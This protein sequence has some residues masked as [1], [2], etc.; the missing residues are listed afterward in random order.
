MATTGFS[1]TLKVPVAVGVAKLE[2]A[3]TIGYDWRTGDATVTVGGE[4]CVGGNLICVKDAKIKITA[5]PELRP[6]GMN[7]PEEEHNP[8]NDPPL[9][10]PDPDA[11]PIEIVF[12]PGAFDTGTPPEE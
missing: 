7:P 11:P 9:I 1:C 2:A 10:E 6:G 3:I 8:W 5:P 4:A 12:P